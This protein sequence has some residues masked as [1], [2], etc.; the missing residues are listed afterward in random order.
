MWEQRLRAVKLTVLIHKNIF[1][2]RLC[3]HNLIPVH[4]TATECVDKRIRK[5]LDPSLD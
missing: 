1:Q 5:M 3:A 2:D 4:P